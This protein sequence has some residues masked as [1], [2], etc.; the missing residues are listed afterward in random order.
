MNEIT[1]P[2]SNKLAALVK[3][4][5]RFIYLGKDYVVV[6][7]SYAEYFKEF[8]QDKRY[9]DEIYGEDGTEIKVKAKKYG[10]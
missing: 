8:P 3:D 4:K 2:E 5:K 1:I 6:A 7:M 10:V 9:F